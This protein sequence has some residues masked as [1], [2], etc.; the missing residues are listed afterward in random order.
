MT[1]IVEYPLDDGG[2]LLIQPASVDS[3]RDDLGLASS[4]GEMTRKARETLEASL[5]TVTPALKVVA[6]KLKGLSSDALTVEFG[7]TLTA[8][9]GIVVAKGSAEVHFKVTF[10]W[11][12]DAMKPVIQAQPQLFTGPGVERTSD[13]EPFPTSLCCVNLQRVDGLGKLARA[14]RAAAELVQDVPGLELRVRALTGCA[15]PGVGP[16]GLFLG[17]RLVLPDVRDLR[18]AA[19]AVALIGQGDQAGGL[20][21]GQDA[22]DPRAWRGRTHGRLAT[23]KTNLLAARCL[24]PPASPDHVVPRAAQ[25]HRA[26]VAE[27]RVGL[28]RRPRTSE[29]RWAGC[30]GRCGRYNSGNGAG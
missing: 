26:A 1:E 23:F 7:L 6:D 24:R 12:R 28:G 11:S 13:T 21:F 22:P 18:V 5:A 30:R 29:R 4:A 8:E 2:V 15:Q 19:S 17:G 10:A 9:T 16:V 14:P 3:Q 20:Q 25:G 27:R